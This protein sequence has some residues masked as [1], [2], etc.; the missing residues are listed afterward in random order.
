MKRLVIRSPVRPY[1]PS[2]RKR[3]RGRVLTRDR[4]L[5]GDDG[6]GN[7]PNMYIGRRARGYSR[8]CTHVSSEH[9]RRATLCRIARRVFRAPPTRRRNRHVVHNTHSQS[10]LSMQSPQF[11]PFPLDLPVLLSRST[12][13]ATLKLSSPVLNPEP[14]DIS[15]LFFLPAITREIYPSPMQRA[16]TRQSVDIREHS[17]MYGGNARIVNLFA[18][19]LNAPPF[20]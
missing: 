20:R 1:G 8:G 19:A 18:P 6:S 9:E 16:S 14:N 10:V 7:V 5:L 15:P 12:H 2:H 11:L 4:L 3:E 13:V 17:T